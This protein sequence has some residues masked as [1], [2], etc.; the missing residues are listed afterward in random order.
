MRFKYKKRSILVPFCEK[1]GSWI[2]GNGSILTPYNCLCGAYRYN[3]KIYEYE[4]IP[5]HET[6]SH[7]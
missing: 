4:P 3:G 2:E 1:C 5:N 6:P 7:P